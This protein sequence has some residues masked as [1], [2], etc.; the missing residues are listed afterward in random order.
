MAE[1]PDYRDMPECYEPVPMLDTVAASSQ[2]QTE[3]I[4]VGF[5]DLFPIR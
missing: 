5:P 3:A 4:V 1:L 2:E